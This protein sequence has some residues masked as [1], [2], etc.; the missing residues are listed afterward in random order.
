MKIN[1]LNSSP[2]SFTKAVPSFGSKLNKNGF[3]ILPSRGTGMRIQ[4]INLF[5]SMTS[6]CTRRKEPKNNPP[7]YIDGTH[8][9]TP[10]LVS[11]YLVRLFGW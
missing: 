10:I 3:Q 8:W 6:G 1:N 9:K 7:I 4:G 5:L 11:A 2:E